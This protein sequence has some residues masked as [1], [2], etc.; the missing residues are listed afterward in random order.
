MERKVCIY[1]ECLLLLRF[2]VAIKME[3]LRTKSPQLF[4][5]NR[6]YRALAGGPGVPAVRYFGQEGQYH[7]LVMDLL[8]PSLEELFNRCGRIFSLKTVL[9]L[10]G[11][12][13]YDSTVFC[14]NLRLIDQLISRL[15]FIHSKNYIHRDIKPDNFLIGR[16]KKANLIHVCRAQ[17]PLLPSHRGYPPLRR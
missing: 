3:P 12:Y 13:K 11:L 1:T 14:Y 9:M 15:E 10:A 5:E 7:A 17:V 2:S 16:G 4:Y 8:G 6:L